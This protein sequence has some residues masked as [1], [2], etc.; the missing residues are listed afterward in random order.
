MKYKLLGII[1]QT[2]GRELPL[3]QVNQIAPKLAEAICKSDILPEW[4]STEYEEPVKNGE[5]IAHIK[6]ASEATVLNFEDG[7]FYDEENNPYNVLYWMEL[8]DVPAETV[9]DGQIHAKTIEAKT[10]DGKPRCITDKNPRGLCSCCRID[11]LLCCMQCA[12]KDDCNI[13]CGYITKV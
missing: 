2:L 7:S 11:G 5:V 8:P 3:W 4:I 1:K 6:G 13:V 12:D 9:T 10:S